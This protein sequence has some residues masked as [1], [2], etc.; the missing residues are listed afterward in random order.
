MTVP[1]EASVHPKPAASWPF[2]LFGHSLQGNRAQMLAMADTAAAAGFAVIAMDAPLHGIQPEDPVLAPLYIGN[3]PFAGVANERTF[4]VDYINNETGAPGPDGITDPTGTHFINPSSLLTTRDNMRQAQVDFS[5][6][7]NSVPSIS[8]DGDMLPDLDASTIHYVSLSLGSILGTAFIA[9]EPMVNNAF[10]S[11]PMGGV[12]RGLE[13]SPTVGPRLRAGLAAAGVEP[14]TSNYEL[15][16][17]IFQTVID[18]ADPVN[19]SAEAAQFN[20]IVL[21]EVQDDSVFPNFVLTAPLSGTEP[22][23]TAM[24]LKAYSSTQTNPSGVDLAGR[25][26]SPASHAS[27]LD[28]STSPAATVEMQKQ[29]A[30]FLATRGTTVVVEDATTMQAAPE[31]QAASPA[32]QADTE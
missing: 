24:G 19:W 6:L 27:L 12:A 11:V 28:P 23:I 15:F 20:N 2:V 9:S 32:P 5:G 17:T 25:F 16:F 30:S 10:L 7:A 21:H 1:N 22:M 8:Y 14:G 4:D 18:S 31:S 3:T 13:A 26:V 29:L